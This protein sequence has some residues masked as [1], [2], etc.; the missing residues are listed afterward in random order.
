MAPLCSFLTACVSFLLIKGILKISAE[1][2]R[3]AI[4]IPLKFL[5]SVAIRQPIKA[6]ISGKR[7]RLSGTLTVSL[8]FSLYFL[9]LSVLGEDSCFVILDP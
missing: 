4:L 6:E 8:I 1:R 9:F 5:I 2:L 3:S 7:V